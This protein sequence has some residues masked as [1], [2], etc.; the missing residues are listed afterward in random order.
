MSTHSL[1]RLTK[2]DISR[3]VECLKDAFEDDPLWAEVFKNDP[4]RDNALTGFFT[5]PLLYGMK[6]GKAYATSPEIEGVAAWVSDKYANMT[7]WHML[8][9]GALPYGSK[10]GKETLRNLSTVNRYIRPRRRS[11]MKNKPYMYLV[12]IGISSAAQGNG[13]GSKIIDAI[14]EESS[15]KGFYIYLETEKEE[16]VVFYEKHGFNVVERIDLEELNV[17]MWLMERKPVS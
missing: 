17:P 4:D 6:F 9:S 16:N 11:L 7:M 10:M 14:K 5:C 8:L 12:I 3:A 2:E 13:F 1:H 15:R